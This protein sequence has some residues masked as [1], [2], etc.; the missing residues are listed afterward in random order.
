MYVVSY[1]IV[2][3]KL[4]NK[5]A[6]VLL[7]YGNRVQYSV[8]ECHISQERFE[9]LYKKLVLLMA[10]VDEGNLRFYHLCGKCEKEIRELGMP[11]EDVTD[12][13]ET[14]IRVVSETH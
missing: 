6:K 2:S 11:K 9:D 14:I 5:V 4:R 3:D 12:L 1:D 10:G 13:E 8:F 7:G